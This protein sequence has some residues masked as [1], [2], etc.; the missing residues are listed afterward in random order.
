MST[1]FN[2]ELLRLARQRSG[3]TISEVALASGVSARS[4]SA[5]ENGSSEPD[6]SRAR[7]IAGVLGVDSEYFYQDDVELVQPGAV[8][9][10]KLSKTSAKQRDA[11][12][13]SASLALSFYALLEER[14]NLPEADLPDMGNL[15]PAEAAEQLR[16]EWLLGDAPVS[17][18]LQ[19]LE[20]KGVRIAALGDDFRDIDAFCFSVDRSNF[21]FVN[22]GRSA[23]RQRF[24]LAHELGHL[25]LHRTCEMD[26]STSKDREAQANEFASNFLMPASALLSQQLLSAG[27]ERIL[28]AKKYWGV[29]AMA[30]VYRLHKLD[31]LSD[32]QY[33]SACTTLARQGYRS[34][35]PDGANPEVSRLLRSVM[36][37]GISKVS[38]RAASAK[39]RVKPPQIQSLVQGLVPLMVA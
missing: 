24:D 15:L 9:F 1:E 3:L 33:R 4:I 19:L 20:S 32:W 38:I 11:A 27:M 34:G 39:L 18:M 17:N 5:Y 10:R 36:F 13:A 21:I 28:A 12:L 30:L 6:G 25:V 2:P 16:Y 31:L 7:E 8:S 22:V 29:S 14:F 37:G 23:E 35:E 26:A